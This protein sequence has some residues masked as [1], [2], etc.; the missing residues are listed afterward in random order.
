MSLKVLWTIQRARDRHLRRAFTLL[1]LSRHLLQRVVPKTS[2]AI[3]SI[4]LNYDIFTGRVWISIM[5]VTQNASPIGT[6]IHNAG[7]NDVR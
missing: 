3:P 2:P 7:S 1:A 4:F 6:K 5:Q